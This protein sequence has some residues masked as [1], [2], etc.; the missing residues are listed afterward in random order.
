M[1]YETIQKAAK[2]WHCQYF[3]KNV[4][5]TVAL[6][7]FSIKETYLTRIFPSIYVIWPFKMS[8]KNLELKK[9]MLTH[10]LIHNINLYRN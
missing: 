8:A 7:A 5:K 1:F 6:S 9:H 2:S 4:P 10:T 3:W